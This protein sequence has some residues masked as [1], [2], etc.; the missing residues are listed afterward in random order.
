MKVTKRGTGTDKMRH[1]GGPRGENQKGLD[2]A[3]HGADTGARMGKDA[4]EDD[5]M[6]GGDRSL[7]VSMFLGFCLGQYVAYGWTDDQVLSLARDQLNL[8]RKTVGIGNN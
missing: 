1:S 2:K 5:E 8:I 7:V 6:P 3:P 4:R